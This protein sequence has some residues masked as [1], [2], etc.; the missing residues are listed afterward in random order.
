MQK[1]LLIAFAEPRPASGNK[2]VTKHTDC[3][4]LY[5]SFNLRKFYHKNKDIVQIGRATREMTDWE[6]IQKINLQ[7]KQL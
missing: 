5:S 1:Q 3:H 7:L 6:W 2:C 4:K